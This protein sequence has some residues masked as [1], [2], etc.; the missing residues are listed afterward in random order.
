MT[1]LPPPRPVDRPA[2]QEHL[3]VRGSRWQQQRERGFDLTRE[4]QVRSV[5]LTVSRVN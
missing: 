3:R 4:L 5:T 1:T 2:A